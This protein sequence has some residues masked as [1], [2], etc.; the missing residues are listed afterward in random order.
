M[1]LTDSRDGKNYNLL[2]GGDKPAVG[3]AISF[4]G[5]VHQGPTLCMQGTAVKISR[6]SRIQLQCPEGAP[7]SGRK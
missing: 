1:V 3:A 2:F 6:W 4:E 7:A 5:E